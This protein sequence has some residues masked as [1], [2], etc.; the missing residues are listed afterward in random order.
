MSCDQK[1]EIRVLEKLDWSPSSNIYEQSWKLKL[2]IKLK[3]WQKTKGKRFCLRPATRWAV[4][5]ILVCKNKMSFASF[6]SV[7]SLQLKQNCIAAFLW[8]HDRVSGHPWTCVP[9]DYRF[10]AKIKDIA[11]FCLWLLSWSGSL[12]YIAWKRLK[13]MS[14]I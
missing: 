2:K 3:E 12:R 11:V 13:R 7:G 5:C 14:W 8:L 1:T 9:L 6:L 4:V 10:R